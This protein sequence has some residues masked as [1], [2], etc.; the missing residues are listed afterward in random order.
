M[1]KKKIIYNG[2]RERIDIFLKT[3]LNY[4]REFIKKLILNGSIKVNSKEV[5]PSYI[6]ICDD[7]IEIDLKSEEKNKTSLSSIIIYEDKDIIVINKPNGMLVHPT[8]DNWM[9]DFSALEFSKNTLVWLLYSQRFSDQLLKM[10]RL[11][12]V[13]RLDSDTSGIMVVAKNEKAQKNLIEQFTQREVS[14][15]YKAVCAGVFEKDFLTVDAPIGRFSGF[16]KLEVMEYGRDAITDFSLIERGKN[17]SYLD[18]FPRTGRTNQI[19]VHL[20]FIKHP[21]VGD[22]IYSKTNYDRLMLF[23]FKITFTHPSKGKK[24][25]FEAEIDKDFK[26]RVKDLIGK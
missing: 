20:S 11:G 16:K 22:K 3:Q 25:V 4:S 19:R 6:L 21:V 26:K 17:F 24:V 5:K 23:S 7:E 14:K 15:N 9:N 13:H 8:D 2:N 1:E 18:V 10:K 12:L